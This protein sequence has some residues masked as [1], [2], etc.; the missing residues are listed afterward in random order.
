MHTQGAHRSDSGARAFRWLDQHET[1]G[2]S[3]FS[4]SGISGASYGR[5]SR[6]KTEGSSSFARLGS[7]V[8]RMVGTHVP[9]LKEA[10][11]S[12]LVSYWLTSWHTRRHSS[13]SR[14]A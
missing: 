7:R 13:S 10:P 8:L 6:P 1:E 4:S 2:S 5:H 11:A 14:A 12:E 3:S 9:R